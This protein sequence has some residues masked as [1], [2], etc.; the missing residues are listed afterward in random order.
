MAAIALRLV[1]EIQLSGVT[2]RAGIAAAL[3]V[4]KVPTARGGSWSHVQVGAILVRRAPLIP[5]GRNY[6]A[7]QLA[8]KNEITLPPA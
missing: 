8:P 5:A 3:N 7:S 2:S 4:R 6:V 1:Q